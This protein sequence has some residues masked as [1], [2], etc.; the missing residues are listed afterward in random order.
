MWQRTNETDRP[1]ISFSGVASCIKD[2][3]DMSYKPWMLAT[4]SIIASTYYT[5]QLYRRIL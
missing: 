1:S 5:I 2:Y 3:N 4:I